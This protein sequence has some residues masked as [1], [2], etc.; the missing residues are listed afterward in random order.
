MKNKDK[1]TMVFHHDWLPILEA[2]PK[3]I[4]LEIILSLIRY[5]IDGTITEINFSNPLEKAVYDNMLEAVQRNKESYLK[6]CEK[7]RENGLKGGRPPK[8]NGLSE[9]P[10]KPNG[11]QEKPHGLNENPND[12]DNDNDNDSL[13]VHQE[14]TSG[15][16]YDNEYRYVDEL[17]D[18][19]LPFH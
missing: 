2:L 5:D 8:P 11:F 15:N 12:N 6:K 14:P 4:A 19:G 16:D 9:N 13:V 18:E 10:N 17:E 1:R 3:E 7:N